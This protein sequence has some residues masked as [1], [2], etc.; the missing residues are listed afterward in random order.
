MCC[1]FYIAND[2][3]KQLVD[4]LLASEVETIEGTTETN[5]I[6]S[7]VDNNDDSSLNCETSESMQGHVSLAVI[8]NV[9]KTEC[10]PALCVWATFSI[11]IG[12]FP[13]L[14]V[15]MESKDKC[16]S[17]NRAVN[18]LFVPL[19]FFLFNLFDLFGRLT[20][21]AI[22]PLFTANNI[23]VPTVCRLI[24][25][26]LFLLCN[27]SDSRLPVVFVS[28]FFPIFFMICFAFSNGYVASM[29]MML[30]PTLIDKKNA[31]LAGTIMVFSLTVGLLTGACISFL[32]VFISQGSI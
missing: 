20:A 17:D 1:R 19:Q 29:C 26:P 8:W 14:T 22:R 3:N 6:V 10:I 30:G 2:V 9:F 25:F 31:A 28:D 27:V 21:G 16:R 12:V 24:F 18:D 23:W 5:P 7:F 32:T 15:F 11:T 4:P 13:S